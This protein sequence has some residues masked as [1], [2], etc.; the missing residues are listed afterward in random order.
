MGLEERHSAALAAS[1]FFSASSMDVPFGELELD[2]CI[3]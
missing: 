1:Y 3:K 2:S